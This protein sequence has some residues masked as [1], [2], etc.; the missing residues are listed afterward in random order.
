MYL[1]VFVHLTYTGEMIYPMSCAKQ[2]I[3]KIVC[4]RHVE[5]VMY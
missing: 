3:I 1:T 4:C 2:V 5:Y